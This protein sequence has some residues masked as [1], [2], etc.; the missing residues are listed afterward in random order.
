LIQGS[1]GAGKT[2]FVAEQIETP[3]AR[4]FGLLLL[5]LMWTDREQR[6][7]SIVLEAIRAATGVTWADFGTFHSFLRE[8]ELTVVVVLDDLQKWL[9][10]QWLDEFSVFVE[11]ISP[12]DRIRWLA[13]LHNTR[14]DDVSSQERLWTRYGFPGA[15]PASRPRSP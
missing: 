15:K 6:I 8:T 13:T 10:P 5:P 9:R 14:Y 2:H 1:L 7:E 3:D 4:P 11:T 12:Y